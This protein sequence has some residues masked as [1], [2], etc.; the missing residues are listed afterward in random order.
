MSTSPDCKASRRAFG[1][2]TKRMVIFASGG[3]PAPVIGEG[4]QI[5]FVVHDEFVALVWPGH[6]RT[7]RAARRARLVDGRAG[8]RER[9]GEDRRGLRRH[10]LDRRR[11][12]GGHLRVGADEALQVGIRR[13]VLLEC[14]DHVIGGDGRAVPELGIRAEGD[15]PGVRVHVRDALREPRLECILRRLEASVFPTCRRVR[16]ACP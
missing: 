12:H 1:S 9:V 10:E 8:Q 11:V 13:P 16:G 14:R 2:P 7:V 3:V 5:E 6:D 4:L 15:A